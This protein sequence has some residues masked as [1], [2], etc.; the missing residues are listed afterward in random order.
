MKHMFLA[1]A[2]AQL[3]SAK[4]YPVKKAEGDLV[5]GLG[6][7]R[8]V[9]E[10]IPARLPEW[11]RWTSAGAMRKSIQYERIPDGFWLEDFAT[12]DPYM[13]DVMELAIHVDSNS[14]FLGL[15]GYIQIRIFQGEKGLAA[16]LFEFVSAPKSKED[17]L[18]IA[19]REI[20][21]ELG[22][23]PPESCPWK[24]FCDRVRAKIGKQRGCGDRTIE[25]RVKA[26]ETED[27]E[28][29]QRDK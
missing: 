4:R 15:E 11:A 8:L 7:G 1:E 19:I 27:N 5:L 24:P 18:T 10:G 12:D 3:A 22:G 6:K 13:R 26:L 20:M 23:P 17:Q 2:V 29:R 16:S 21:T 25:R 14:A 28:L 9:A